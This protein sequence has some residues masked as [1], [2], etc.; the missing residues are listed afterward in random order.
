MSE[1]GQN[2]MSAAGSSITDVPL[3][4][5]PLVV[6]DENTVISERDHRQVATQ[7]T[8]VAEGSAGLRR[9]LF[10]ASEAEAGQEAG[11][12]LGQFEIRR[13]IGAGGMGVVFLATDLELSRDV[14]LKVLHPA[15][16]GDPAHVARFRNEARACARLNHDN[17]AR[18]YLSG[19]QDGFF[20]IAYEL[21]TG[22]TIRDLIL[23]RGRLSIEEAVNYAIQVTLA[24]NHLDAEGV[25]H[26]DIKPSNIM[27]TER[28]RVKVVDLGLARREVSDSIGDLTVAGTTLG[29]FDY[30]APEQARDPR[31]ADIRSDIYSLG[32]TL[33]QMLTGRPPYPEG[34]ALQKL[35]DHQGKSP[36]DP[37]SLNSQIPPQLGA[38]LRK[39][40]A[41]N[42]E[43]RYQAPALLLSDL[44]QIA[45]SLGLR[46]VPADGIVW[47]KSDGLTQRSPMG[48]AW[49]FGSVLVICLTAIGLNW[50]QSNETRPSVGTDPIDV[51]GDQ[52]SPEQFQQQRASASGAATADSRANGSGA[53]ESTSQPG[54]AGPETTTA[55]N[56]EGPAP[57]PGAAASG[58]PGSSSAPADVSESW[59]SWPLL[60]NGLQW[61]APG[62]VAA[63]PSEAAPPAMVTPRV[64]GRFVLQSPEGETQS[65]QTLQAA[66]AD[67]RSGDVIL[68]QYDGNPADIA[69]QPPVRISGINLI[70]RAAPGFRP[71]LEFRAEADPGGM[72]ASMFSIR[73]NASLTLRDLDLRFRSAADVVADTLSIFRVDGAHRLQLDNLTVDVRS[74]VPGRVSVVQLVHSPGS[75]DATA[76]PA[77]NE[78]SVTNSLI[79]GSTDVFRLQ[80]QSRAAIRMTNTGL[81][82][83]G[84]VFVN[85]GNA[86]MLQSTGIIDVRLDHVTAVS[87]RSLVL[88]R[89]SDELTGN[90]SQR[91]LPPLVIR[92]DACVFA[93]AGEDPR[94]VVSEG[95]AYLE[96]LEELLTWTA[97][98]N[99]YFN[100]DVFWQIDTAAFDYSSR[101]LSFADWKQHW[102]GRPDCE[103]NTPTL[104][105]AEVWLEPQWQSPGGIS[106]LSRVGLRAFRLE[107]ARFGAAA[108]MLPLG[109]DG[110]VPG[111]IPALLHSFPQ[112]ESTAR[113]RTAPAGSESPRDSVDAE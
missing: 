75:A 3:S 85:L 44:I 47:R 28:G 112:P 6:P 53:A 1:Q 98:T 38:V 111:V 27:L 108:G 15:T 52:L 105:D 84:C 17:I 22:V 82:V 13:R 104:M 23:Q 35:L 24:L 92:S 54:T 57:D 90:G 70:I 91:V 5:R 102:L 58:G 41:S 88:M 37:R 42:P 89:D 2:S 45:A 16:S 76:T 14:A 65:F 74:E 87:G 78:I 80:T 21:A 96:D 63:E 10:P 68:L 81:A 79:R 8:V 94:L 93:G 109:R 39:M 43:Q 73:N 97:F 62:R 72:P 33:Y 4:E 56:G 66:V 103:E 101:R 9:R 20:F 69:A 64:Q 60:S 19:H 48:A 71:L 40:M 99:L 51:P 67:A 11:V 29:T 31:D 46:S 49:L 59:L 61:P 113:D 50:M 86:S 106:D 77:E 110:K 34:T 32:C 25:V 95:N 83:D 26:R 30:I 36:P 55:A 12:R 107:E 7:E 18:V 100:Y